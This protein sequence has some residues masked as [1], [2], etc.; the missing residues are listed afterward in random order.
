M[1][2]RAPHYGE[3]LG[4]FRVLPPKIPQNPGVVMKAPA[5]GAKAQVRSCQGGLAVLNMQLA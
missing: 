5:D 2:P 4:L 3:G 1:S